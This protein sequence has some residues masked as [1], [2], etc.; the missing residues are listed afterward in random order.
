MA[1]L[2][3]GSFAGYAQAATVTAQLVVVQRIGSKRQN[4]EAVVWLSP[5]Q[6]APYSFGETSSQGTRLVQKNKTFEPHLLVVRTG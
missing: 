2:A 6:P 3:V 5:V 1:L 4:S